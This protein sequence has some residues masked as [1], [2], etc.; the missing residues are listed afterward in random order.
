MS[1]YITPETTR[2]LVKVV[3]RDDPGEVLGQAQTFGG[4]KSNLVPLAVR[5]PSDGL[6]AY[7]DENSVD[8]WIGSAQ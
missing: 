6:C 4:R 5:F 3:G 8:P 7:Y 1:E 2:R